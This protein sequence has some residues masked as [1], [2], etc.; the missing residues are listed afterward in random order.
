MIQQIKGK[1]H[2][3]IKRDGRTEKYSQVKLKKAI[4]WC[5]DGKT[6]LTDQLF[7]ALNIK[8][9]NKIKIEKLWDEVISTSANMISEMYPIWDSVAKRSFMLKI[10]KETYG[11]KSDLYYPDYLE[12]V[13]KGIQSG[14]YDKKVISTFSDDE[15]Q[16]LAKHI[17][18]ERDLDFTFIGLI[19]MHDKYCLNYSI[20]KKLELPQHA[21]MRIAIYP[22]YK[23]KDKDE[24][25]KLIIQ[26]YN[27]LSLH[28]FT[29]ATPK[30]VNSLTPNSQM[31]SCVLNTVS[32]D[33]ESINTTGSNI[34]LF[35]KYGGGTAVDVSAIRGKGSQIGKLGGKSSGA[36]NFIKLYES[37]IV[38]YNQ[39]GKRAGACVVTYPFWHLDV[40][41]ILMLKDAGG[42]DDNRARKLQYALK[43]YKILSKRIQEDGD[44]TL[45]DPKDTPKLNETWGDEFEE[46]Y[47]KYEDKVSVKKRKIKARELAFLIAKVRSETGNLYITFVDN[48]NKQRVGE[49]P[50]FSS[51]LCQ[52]IVIPSRPE[53]PI[54]TDLIEYK[55]IQD[56]VV[57]VKTSETGEI[58]LCNLSSIN[59][60]EWFKLDNNQKDNLIYNLLIASDNLIDL[61]Y[62]PVKDGEFSNSSRRPIGIG[63]NNYANYLASKQ[64]LF[65][66]E[67]ARQVTHELMEDITYFILKGSMKLAKERGSYSYFKDSNWAKGKLPMDLYL[68]KNDAR[69]N[70]P[71][72]HD[73]D[74]LREDIINFGVRFSYHFAIAPTTSSGLVINSTEGIEP[75][76]T[77]FSI[78]EGTYTQP[79]IVPNLQKNRAYYQNAFDIPNSVIYDLAS[80]R[81]KFLDQSQSVSSYYKKT[82][83]AFEMIKDI[84]RAEKVGLKTL[85]YLTPMKSGESSEESCESCSS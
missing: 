27:D 66:D 82:D 32:D 67:M 58:G 13:K 18:P 80:I 52:E 69:Y 20:T 47:L 83:S 5:T 74:S 25:I 65:T 49:E 50:V 14:V 35:S 71:L 64:V 46:W 11:L 9:Y 15:F 8:I 55:E 16:L 70:F 23:V 77:L 37:Y 42:S 81:Q 39:N 78:R 41:D 17:K 1:N 56:K 22:F 79:H 24:R 61:A 12:V 2:L 3:V 31:S 34:G 19:F 36:I 26:R 75:V 7:Q 29:E 6:V 60:V 43:W 84:I 48:I 57:T 44:I 51:N 21:Y 68:M 30:V 62:Y 53:T 85:Y 33:I 40:F 73:W 72:K 76:R 10:Y 59:V 63:I 4:D 54:K 45:F 38:A 28:R